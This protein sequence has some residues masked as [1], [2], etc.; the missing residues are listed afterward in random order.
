MR[1]FVKIKRVV[2]SRLGLEELL[3]HRK[4]YKRYMQNSFCERKCKD[5]IQYEACITRLYHTI[6]KGLSY[7]NYRPGFGEKN[8]SALLAEMEEYAKHFDTD[9]FFYKTALC[10]LLEYVKRNE[11]YGLKDEKLK[12][13]I[14]SLSGTC[15]NMGGAFEFDAPADDFVSS[16]NFQVLMEN[17]HS[18]RDFGDERVNLE[19]LKKAIEI[20]QHTPSACNRQGWHTIVIS[21]KDKVKEVLKNQNGNRGFGE[22]ID[23]LLLVVGDLRFFNRRRELYQV[24]IDGGMYAANLLNA[25][26]FEN[27]ASVPLSASLNMDQERRIRNILQLN[28]AEIPILFIGV[29]GYRDKNRT[30]MST[31]KPANFVMV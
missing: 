28:E 12:K 9:A 26:Y 6:E 21:E 22:R 31:R 8:I 25:L 17:R 29:G 15:N 1:I 18:I 23:K 19:R 20:A 13:Q 10:T 3:I 11:E 5:A 24:Y 7:R 16:A 14:R 27:I 2:I 30:T 4:Y